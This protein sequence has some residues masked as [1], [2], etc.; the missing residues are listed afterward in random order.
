MRCLYCNSHDHSKPKCL[1]ILCYDC[2]QKG[3][4]GAERPKPNFQRANVCWT[5][6]RSGHKRTDKESCP[7]SSVLFCSF[8][9]KTGISS[10]ACPCNKVSTRNLYR[11]SIA[12]RLGRKVEDRSFTNS[13][14]RET[15]PPISTPT[16][17]GTSPKTN[18]QSS[19]TGITPRTSS[20]TATIPKTQFIKGSAKIP[21][22]EGA[23]LG[24][25]TSIG[26]QY[27]T[28]ATTPPR[29]DHLSTPIECTSQ[30]TME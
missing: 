2:E 23:I 26:S 11:K 8:C 28:A 17:N 10:E 9:F 16:Y 25:P 19:T 3:H 20:T 27:I 22:I 12:Y 4:I 18:N 29:E 1:E 6:K 21:K 5:C 7:G 30:N 13:K 15:P 24:I 14:Q